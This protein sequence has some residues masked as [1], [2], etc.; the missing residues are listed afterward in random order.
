MADAGAIGGG[1]SG[2]FSGVSSLFAAGSFGQAANIYGQ[3]IQLSKESTAL[4]EYV[5]THEAFAGMGATRAAYGAAGLK[6]SGS[7][8]DVLGESAK[9]ASLNKSQ[10]SIQGAI[11]QND[12]LLK[13]QA[14]KSQETSS[15][16]GGIG[17]I[18]GGAA[19]I[20][21]GI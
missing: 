1:I 8:L 19:S 14:A 17:G 6:T 7:A 13:Q 18:V 4:K 10:I 16:I 9:L 12:F 21:L 5:A 20:G 11:E 3:D 15:I 2:L